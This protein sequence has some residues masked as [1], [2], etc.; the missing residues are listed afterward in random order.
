MEKEVVVV[1]DDVSPSEFE[2]SYAAAALKIEDV[3][4]ALLELG[5]EL[6]A[7]IGSKRALQVEL[8]HFRGLSA[9]KIMHF[10]RLIRQR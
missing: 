3:R 2:D 5:F 9:S 10:D 4:R 1:V 6:P 8:D 7:V